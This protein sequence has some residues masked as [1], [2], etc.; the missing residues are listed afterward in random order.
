MGLVYQILSNDLFMLGKISVVLNAIIHQEE[1]AS[2]VFPKM[3]KRKESQK[4]IKINR[5]VA[6][7]MGLVEDALT[8]L[9]ITLKIENKK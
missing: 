1:N 2:T 7:I 8:A 4:K 9:T 6:A 5:K 3:T